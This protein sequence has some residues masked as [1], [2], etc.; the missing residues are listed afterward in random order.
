MKTFRSYS[1]RETAEFGAALAEKIMQDATKSRDGIRGGT[2]AG[3]H[4]TILALQGDLGAGKTT[5]TQGF[6]HGLGIRRRTA[7]PT[8]VIMRRFAIPA[9]KARQPIFKNLYH[10]DAYRL[11][12]LDSLEVL[13]L[14]EIFNNP[15]NVVLI[16][17]PEKI[18]AALPKR[19]ILLK[20]GYGKKENERIIRFSG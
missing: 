16:E 20:F 15:E 13:G 11:K 10:I 2:T 19:T 7:S 12:K 1:S 5:F 9:R 14:D 3:S 18:K 17:W 8:F 6:A 4:A